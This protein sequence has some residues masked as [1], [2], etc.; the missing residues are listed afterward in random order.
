MQNGTLQHNFIVVLRARSSARFRPEAGQEFFIS[1]LPGIVGTV[2][3]RLRTRWVDEGFEAPTPRE[4]WIEA[5]GPA[6]T[7]DEAI[8]KFS[9]AGRLLATLLAF[10][11]NTSVKTPEVHIAYD[12]SS[13]CTERAFLEVFLPDERGHPREGR[14]AQTAEFSELFAKLYSSSESARI[15]RALEHYQIALREAGDL[16]LEPDL[17]RT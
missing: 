12:A 11:A 15:S 6:P 17:A 7:L 13:G 2:R 16:S 1:G 4:L 3:M 9:A 8:A 10:C 14:L 5:L